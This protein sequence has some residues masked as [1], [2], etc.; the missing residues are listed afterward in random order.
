MTGKNLPQ[1]K[2]RF[3]LQGFFFTSAMAIAEPSTVFPLIVN[4]FSNSNALVGLFTA[5]IKGGA[6]LMQLWAAYGIQ[7]S[8]KV[9]PRMRMVFV[10]RLVTWLS[11]G[12]AI[13]F[14]AHNP[15]WALIVFGISLFLF[16]FSAGFGAVYFQEITGKI[17]TKEFRGKAMAQRQFW[18]GVASIASGGITALVLTSLDKPYNYA[19]VFFV[20]GVVM[21]ASFFAFG[22]IKEPEKTQFT[23]KKENFPDFLRHALVILKTD[24]LL[25]YQIVSRFFAYAFLMAMPF[26]V[27]QAKHN[28]DI[29]GTDVG[30]FVSMHMAGAM[31]SNLLWGQLSSRNKNKTIVLVAFAMVFVGFSASLFPVSKYIYYSVFFLAGAALDGFRLAYQHMVLIIAPEAQRPTYVAI[32]NNIA[33]LGLFFSIPGGILLDFVGYQILVVVTLVFIVAGILFSLKLKNNCA[34][35]I[36]KHHD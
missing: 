30:L 19:T 13:V 29:T 35:V 8:T 23:P 27:L 17:F 4:Y 33:S 15:T 36:E 9:M 1:N 24:K 11:L 2:I 7:Q 31:L 12:L 20:S 10:G 21:S 34:E 3:I 32:Q 14:F 22:T 25:L 18:S 6:F 16:S 28:F 5:L 26:V